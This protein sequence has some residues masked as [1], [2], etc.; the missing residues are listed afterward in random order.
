MYRGAFSKPNGVW[1][2]VIE[3]GLSVTALLTF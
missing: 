1:S 3:V 2:S